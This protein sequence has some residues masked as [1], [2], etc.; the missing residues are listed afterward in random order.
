MRVKAVALIIGALTVVSTIGAA[1]ASAATEFGDPCIA[2]RGTGEGFEATVFGISSTSSPFPLAAPSAGVVTSWKL[3]LITPPP[4]SRPIP[5][6]IPQTLKVLRLNTAAHIAQVVGEASGVVGSGINT[7]PA[8]IPVQAGDRLGTFGRGPITFEGSTSEVGTLICEEEAGPE[9]AIGA[10]EGNV[11]TGGS[12][13]YEEG[14]GKIRV[15]AVAVLEPDADNDGYGDETQDKCP[16]N[17]TTQVAC[18]VVT[19]STTS[20]VKRG[21]VTIGVTANLQATVTMAGTVKLGKGK[22]VTLNGGTQIVAPGT[23]AQ[24][25]LLFP[26]KLRSALKALPKKRSLSLNIAA[27]A[28]NVVGPATASNLTVKLK[29]QAKPKAKIHKAKKGH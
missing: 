28:P 10:Y 13:A 20:S 27:T 1:S 19:L 5:A 9:N 21:L 4:P 11:T 29:G 2:N 6:I 26:K 22:S 17:A 14:A 3:D 18:P 24:F 15:P 7:I 23:I 12:T 8:R 16:Q 25:T